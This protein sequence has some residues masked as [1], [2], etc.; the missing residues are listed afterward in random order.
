MR[1]TFNYRY[2]PPRTQVKDLLMNGEIGDVLSVDFHWLL[3]T[4]ARHRLLP[5]LAQPEEELR[6][7]DDPQ[8]HA[9]TSTW[10]TG[11]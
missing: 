3:N 2:S 9:T 1:V 7:P 8:G 11:G 5:A 4:D 6:R 10:S